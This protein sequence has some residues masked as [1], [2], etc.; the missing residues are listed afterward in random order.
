[1]TRQEKVG[2]AALAAVALAPVPAFAHVGVGAAS[3]TACST[4]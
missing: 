2:L 3:E 4:L 1:M